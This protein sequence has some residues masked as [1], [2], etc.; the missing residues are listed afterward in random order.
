MTRARLRNQEGYALVTALVLMTIMMGVGLA[1]L[2]AVDTGQERVREQRVR[3]TALNLT[4]GVLYAQ[5]FALASAW[6]GDDDPTKMPPDTCTNGSAGVVGCPDAN[7]LAQSNSGNGLANFTNVDASMAGVVW[8]TRVRDNGAPLAVFTTANANQPQS[9]TN[10]LTGQAY[11]CAA[12]C[13]YDAN[14]DRQLWV[15]AR[16]TIDG[17]PRNVVAL[18]RLETLREAAPTSAVIAGGLVATNNGTSH[19]FVSA[20]GS[21]VIVR[22]SDVDPDSSSCVD[23]RTKPTPQLNP[24][25]TY[26]PTTPTSLLSSTQIERLK[27]VA[28]SL[29]TFYP[30]GQCPTDLRGAVVFVENCTYAKYEN[31]TPWDNCVSPPPTGMSARCINQAGKPGILIWQCGSMEGAGGFTYVGLVYM[32][33][34]SNGACTPTGTNPI[35]CPSNS[36]I[37]DVLTT[38]GG[39]GI[40]GAAA[41]D[42]NGCMKLGSNSMQVK[43]DPNVFNNLASYGAVGLVQNTWRELGANE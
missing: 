35:S 34:G 11:T 12:P 30:A 17:K 9:G 41:V 3:E 26:R 13:R 37:Y 1:L 38:N 23:Y 22:C 36:T 18:L 10:A 25:P 21:Q 33:N 15:Q 5:G 40:W 7:Y 39:F 42:G 31:S 28:E 20:T 16:A 4:E 29:G 14:G 43:Y 19:L 32:V 24:E 8:E 6:P 2:D 27:G